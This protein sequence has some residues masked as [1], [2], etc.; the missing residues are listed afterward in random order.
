[1]VINPDRAIIRRRIKSKNNLLWP[2]TPPSKKTSKTKSAKG[3]I[4]SG[5]MQKRTT[6]FEAKSTEHGSIFRGLIRPREIQQLGKPISLADLSA[7]SRKIRLR[8][9]AY[10]EICV[11]AC[12]NMDVSFAFRSRTRFPAIRSISRYGR[13]LLCSP[14]HR[15]RGSDPGRPSRITPWISWHQVL[16]NKDEKTMFLNAVT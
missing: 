11:I 5:L 13:N 9:L 15:R 1:M 4:D 12:R 8:E 10:A 7:A 2:H 16:C 14:G 6:R 3:F